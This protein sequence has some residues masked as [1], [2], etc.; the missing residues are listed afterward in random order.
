MPQN[1]VEM[2]GVKMNVEIADYIKAN[3]FFIILRDQEDE[4]PEDDSSKKMSEHKKPEGG[5]PWIFYWPKKCPICGRW[6]GCMCSRVP[7]P[8]RVLH[9]FVW[10]FFFGTI[11]PR[12]KGEVIHHKNLDKMDA[13]IK[14]LGK[15]TR[16]SHGL[17]HKARRQRFSRRERFDLGSMN[18]RPRLP[19]RVITRA[20]LIGKTEKIPPKLPPMPSK[21]RHVQEVEK[22]LGV[23]HQQLSLD[24][25]RLDSGEPITKSAPSSAWRTPKARM[26]GLKEPRLESTAGEAAFVLLL[27][28]HRF[29]LDAVALATGEHLDLLRAFYERPAVSEAVRRWRE[30]RRLPLATS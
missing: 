16:R 22:R 30:H 9:L 21:A 18:F 25:A 15:G 28:R 8:Y 26:L 7:V 23:R 27:V 13:R 10:D 14:K 20:D 12:K 6:D 24:M 17:A 1:W 29:D 19:A 4:E 5:Y 2:Y 11:R 3:N